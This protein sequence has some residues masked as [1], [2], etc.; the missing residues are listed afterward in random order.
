MGRVTAN[1]E[2]LCSS[3]LQLYRQLPKRGK[4]R[5]ISQRAD[6]FDRLTEKPWQGGTLGSTRCQLLSQ[7][8]PIMLQKN[9]HFNDFFFFPKRNDWYQ[10]SILTKLRPIRWNTTVFFLIMSIQVM[11]FLFFL[12]FFTAAPITYASSQA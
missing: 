4:E 11:L 10:A 2:T 12:S 6:H 5:K 9:N 7:N 3:Q 1:S 8:H